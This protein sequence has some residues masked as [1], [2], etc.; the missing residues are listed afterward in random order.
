MMPFTLNVFLGKGKLPKALD[1]D[2]LGHL[3]W[4]TIFSYVLLL[5]LALPR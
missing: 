1:D 2:F 3:I 5:P 4:V